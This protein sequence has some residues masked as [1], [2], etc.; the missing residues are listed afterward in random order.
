MATIIRTKSDIFLKYLF[1]QAC[2]ED[3]LIDFIN[4]VFDDVGQTR[5]LSA[6]VQN[7]F[8]IK[9][10]KND[11]DSILDIKCET[12][13]N[14]IIN[15]E[16]QLIGS[17][18]Y[19]KRALYYWAKCYSAQL[20]ESEVYGLLKPVISIHLLDFNLFEFD[21]N[22][23]KAKVLTDNKMHHCFGIFEQQNKDLCFSK[24]FQMHIIEMPKLSEQLENNKSLV[25]WIDFFKN[26]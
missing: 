23:K 3:L 25:S 17:A 12:D 11:K 15:I 6:K 24:D 22:H 13:K 4:S 5:V 1:G 7:P 21:E 18:D 20:N 19:S 8:N 26:I 2:N 14:E 9:Q 10:C 16:M